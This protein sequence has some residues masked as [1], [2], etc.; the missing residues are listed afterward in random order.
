MRILG[1]NISHDASS[2]LVED[3]EVIY[4]KQEERLSRRKHHE[5]KLG[6]VDQHL[7]HFNDLLLSY[8][9]E[10]DYVI[11]SRYYG[12]D[13]YF[14]RIKKEIDSQLKVKFKKSICSPVNHHIYHA[15]SAFYFSEFDE[16]A[17]IVIDGGGAISRAIQGYEIES[18]FHC[19]KNQITLKHGHLNGRLNKHDNVIATSSV[20][21]SYLFNV[22]SASLGYKDHG[23]AAGKVMGLSTYGIITDDT[24]WF[25]T[26]YGFPV[27]TCSLNPED[28]KKDLDTFQDRANLCR[29]LQE[30]S[31]NITVK[32]IEKAIKITGSKNIIL[33]GGYA[34]NCLNNY[35]Y[36]QHF[37]KD[38]NIFVD[39][40]PDDSGTSLGAALH[41][42]NKLK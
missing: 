20:G 19:T 21:P 2:C 4:F 31:F 27:T 41:L 3:G 1:I 8:T 11:Y 16:A 33:S 22:I 40:I 42:Y 26:E 5:Y 23:F 18:I 25:H 7:I 9:D 6:K 34:L 14:Q 10:V 32:I 30:E 36:L 15:N 24:P 17:C 35:R 39:P 29:K 37:G 28:Y 12:R 13:Q 38:I